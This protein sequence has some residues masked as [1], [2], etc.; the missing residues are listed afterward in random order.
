CIKVFQ[1]IFTI[2]L[3]LQNFTFDFPWLLWL[4]FYPTN[5]VT[6]DYF[7]LLPWFGIILIGI[8]FGKLLYKNNKRTFKISDLSNYLNIKFVSFLGKNSLLIYLMHQPLLILILFLL[9]FL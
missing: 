9:G 3:I 5:M 2:G 7:P 4:G 6:F 1:N 8:Y